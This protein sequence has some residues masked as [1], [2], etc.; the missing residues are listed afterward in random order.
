MGL[1]LEGL[2]HEDVKE[3]CKRLFKKSS[4]EM[5]DA[6]KRIK[7]VL[8]IFRGKPWCGPDPLQMGERSAMKLL[9][10]SDGS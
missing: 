5:W 4:G 2:N 10:I 6:K 3:E 9:G 1:F 7:R 8:E